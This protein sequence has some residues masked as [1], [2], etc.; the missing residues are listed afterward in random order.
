MFCFLPDFNSPPSPPLPELFNLPYGDQLVASTSWPG[1]NQRGRGFALPQ[2]LPVPVQQGSRG[3]QELPG[4]LP[5]RYQS[6]CQA[7]QVRN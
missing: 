5:D 1:R 2:A 7:P 4:E 6:S 3:V